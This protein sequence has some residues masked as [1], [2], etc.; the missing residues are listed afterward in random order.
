MT[1][2]FILFFSPLKLDNSFYTYISKGINAFDIIN[3][4]L[5]SLGISIYLKVILT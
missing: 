5:T 4:K 2:N 3:K 1:C